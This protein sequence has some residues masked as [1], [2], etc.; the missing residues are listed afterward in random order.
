M[1]PLCEVMTKTETRKKEKKKIRRFIRGKRPSNGG[2]TRGRELMYRKR[3]AD[4]CREKKNIFPL[5]KTAY[6]SFLCHI[7]VT[8]FTKL[9]FIALLS[10][11]V[12]ACA[13]YTLFTF[14]PLADNPWRYFFFCFFVS[15]RASNRFFSSVLSL[16]KIKLKNTLSEK[17]A[18]TPPTLLP[19]L[20]PS[21][22]RVTPNH[23]KRSRTN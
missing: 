23:N 8:Y 16:I 2:S 5:L 17:P 4:F 18:H 13:C 3:N 1:S 22:C 14:A 12:T 15:E 10:S 11:S 9:L 6:Q 20:F 19:S 21:L 7:N